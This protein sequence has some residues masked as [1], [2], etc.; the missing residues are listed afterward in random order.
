VTDQIKRDALRASGWTDADK[1]ELDHVIPLSDRKERRSKCQPESG[2]GGGSNRPVLLPERSYIKED[3]PLAM[4]SKGPGVA[5]AF[6]VLL[7]SGLRSTFGR[8]FACGRAPAFGP[9][10]RLGAG[11]A[12]RGGVGALIL[13]S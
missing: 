10:F 1:F 8:A 5:R 12:S 2:A 11:C 9:G 4:R 6:R 13:R 7:V 3:Q